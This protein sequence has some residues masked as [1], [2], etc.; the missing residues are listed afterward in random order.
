MIL[1]LIVNLEEHAQ[2]VKYTKKVLANA[3]LQQNMM[4]WLSQGLYNL[5]QKEEAKKVMHRVR[6]IFGELSPADYYLDLYA[7]D[8]ENV[9]YSMGLPYVEKIARYKLLDAF[10]KM[11][12][13]DIAV[14]LD[15]E[16]KDAKELKKSSAGRLRTTTKSSNCSSSI[17]WLWSD[18]RGRKI[19]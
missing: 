9:A 13:A 15:S 11:S 1:P 19:L 8:P 3:D 5:G 7:T 14:L 16:D 4:L 17:A 18:A 12:P 10:L 6:T 2:V